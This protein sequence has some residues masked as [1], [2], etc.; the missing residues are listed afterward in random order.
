MIPWRTEPTAPATCM[1]RPTSAGGK[2]WPC[3]P[4]YQYCGTVF[5]LSPPKTKGGKWTEKVLHSFAGGTDGA[6]PNGGLS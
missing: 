5:K 4:D 2:A 1:E 3:D 6:T